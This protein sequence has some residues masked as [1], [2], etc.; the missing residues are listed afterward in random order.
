MRLAQLGKNTPK[1]M[2]TMQKQ[3]KREKINNLFTLCLKSIQ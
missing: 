2:K 3:Y 1:S